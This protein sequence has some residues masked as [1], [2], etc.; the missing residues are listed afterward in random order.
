MENLNSLF[1]KIFVTLVANK[2]AFLLSLFHVLVAPLPTSKKKYLN[3]FLSPKQHFWGKNGLY[4]SH[5]KYFL[6]GECLP[7][8]PFQANYYLASNQDVLLSGIDPLKH[9]LNSGIM[10]GRSPHPFVDAAFLKQQ[11]NIREFGDAFFEFCFREKNWLIKSSS[12]VSVEGFLSQRKTTRG[13]N[14]VFELFADLPES[15]PWVNRRMNTISL[16]AASDSDAINYAIAQILTN[17]IKPGALFPEVMT[18]SITNSELPIVQVENLFISPGVFVVQDLKVLWMCEENKKVSSVKEYIFVK[19]KLVF[20]RPTKYVNCETLVILE[21]LISYKDLIEFSQEPNEIL[22]S[23]PNFFSYKAISTFVR[24]QHLNNVLVLD[25]D[26]IYE[27]SVISSVIF[28]DQSPNFDKDLL[29]SSE[30]NDLQNDARTV[31]LV[32]VNNWKDEIQVPITSE[33]PLGDVLIVDFE[34]PRLWSDL[35]SKY[36]RIVTSS[37]HFQNCLLE[38]SF[39]QQKMKGQ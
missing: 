27:I 7:N 4:Q 9:F 26:Q 33:K 24:E 34:N 5:K 21:G 17:S 29:I 15:L 2:Q 36:S 22:I 16:P 38:V 14:P 10:E 1:R 3:S 18:A 37:D 28:W 35:I 23:P 25:P 30:V 19:D 39:L 13:I 31:V 11:M 8:S 20:T 12:L 32:D 6:T